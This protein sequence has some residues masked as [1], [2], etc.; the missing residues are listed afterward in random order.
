LQQHQQTFILRTQISTG[1]FPVP[2]DVESAGITVLSVFSAAE[3]LGVV[4][5]VLSPAVSI[6]VVS[7]FLQATNAATTRRLKIEFFIIILFSV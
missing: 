4:I 2:A 7:L 6:V 5:A 1:S 3:S